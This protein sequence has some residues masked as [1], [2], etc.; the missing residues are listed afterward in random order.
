MSNL[1][2]SL[3]EQVQGWGRGPLS[4]FAGKGWMVASASRSRKDQL[5][6]NGHLELH[7]DVPDLASTENVF[8]QVKAFVEESPSVVIYNGGSS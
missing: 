1:L 4:V 6:D 3:L 5:L 2:Y 8:D 7:V